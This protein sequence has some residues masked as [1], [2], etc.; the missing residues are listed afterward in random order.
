[1]KNP[2]SRED[3]DHVERFDVC[4]SDMVWA[5]FFFFAGI[6]IGGICTMAYLH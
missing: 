2:Y 6:A 1:M 3:Y 4:N 5:L